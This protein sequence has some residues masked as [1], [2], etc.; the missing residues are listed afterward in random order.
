MSS[1]SAEWRPL[2]GY[3][4]GQGTV[5]G[6]AIRDDPGEAAAPDWW[7][8]A[9]EMRMTF[10]IP[11]F[12]KVRDKHE[13]PIYVDTLVHEKPAKTTDSAGGTDWLRVGKRGCGKSTDNLQWGE[14]LM[15]VN[16]ETVVWRGAAGRSEW[17]PFG[18]WT[19]LW[20]PA[21]AEVSAEWVYGD[22][23]TPAEDVDDLDGEV[24]EVRR[25]EDVLDL[26]ES[27]ADHPAGTFNV[28]Y[29][30]PSFSGC[31]ELCRRTD[32]TPET[33]P[34]TPE[35]QALGDAGGTPV[36]HW[37]YAFILGRIEFA[38]SY[39]WTS[40]IFD[41]ARDLAPQDVEQ[42]DHRS[43]AKASLFADLVRDSRRFKFSIYATIHREK[44]L[45]WMVSEQFERR[46]DMPDGT[47]NPRKRRSKSHPQGWSSVP[48]YADVMSTRNVGTALMYDESTFQLY[49]WK[50]IWAKA[51][52]PDRVLKITL[53]QPETDEDE[54]ETGPSVQYDPRV[55]KEWRRP[56][57]HRLYV[58][59]PGSGYIDLM[60][61]T[62]GEPLESPE[63]G[64]R[65]G[66]IEEAGETYQ[67]RLLPDGGDD[68]EAGESTVVAEFPKP[69][70]GLDVDETDEGETGAANP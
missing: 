8:D 7:T 56:D 31:E 2:D 13:Y 38:S 36:R 45:F 58:R 17:L 34:F 69:S 3:D 29:P 65:F 67:V 32:R 54:E 9:Y 21:N 48:M 44:Q 62:E 30:D 1:D 10:G 23:E 63:P 66:A 59:D 22:D 41:E 4:V 12:K 18:P 5:Q 40:L 68:P 11:A 24:R 15:E 55:F 42:D 37:W 20:L 51:E 28:V 14:R 6:R 64:L 19:T 39:G 47:E 53:D 26:V 35:W 61:G 70:L 49:S 16:D 27:L 57:E 52:L 25:Y 33:L 46:I 60:N 43:Y 50:D